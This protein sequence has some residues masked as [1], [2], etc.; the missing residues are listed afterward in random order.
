MLSKIKRLTRGKIDRLACNTRM[1]EETIAA[2]KADPDLYHAW[3]WSPENIYYIGDCICTKHSPK[4]RAP[5]I[6]A[7]RGGS[8]KKRVSHVALIL[9]GKIPKNFTY[10]ASHRCGNRRCIKHLVWES[11]AANADRRNCHEFRTYSVCPH[12]CPCVIPWYT[13]AQADA[14]HAEVIACKDMELACQRVTSALGAE[15]FLEALPLQTP[16]EVYGETT[17]LEADSGLQYGATATPIDT[18]VAQRVGDDAYGE[19]LEYSK[20]QR[21][22]AKR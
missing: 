15:T 17:L 7:G 18:D 16:L 19:W 3:I 8:H 1:Y 14:A 6:G 20:W 11:P 13:K 5:K 22:R 21:A 10:E 12:T 4:E 9:Q 2:V